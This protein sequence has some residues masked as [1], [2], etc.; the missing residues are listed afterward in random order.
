MRILELFKGTGSVGAVFRDLGHEVVSLDIE[1]KYNPTICADIM[2]WDYKS[3][4]NSGEF[5]YVVCSPVCLYWSKIRATWIG[6]K[7]KT[8]HPTDIITAEHIQKDIEEKGIPM[9]EKTFE[10]IE[11]FRPKWWWIENP[12]SSKM[13]KYIETT[14]RTYFKYTF[15]YCKYG[16]D[17][18]KPTTFITNIENIVPLRCKKDCDAIIT[19]ATRE[20]DMHQG[21]KKPIKGKTRTIHKQQLGWRKH[22]IKTINEE[23]EKYNSIGALTT[24]EQRYSIPAG[25]IRHLVIGLKN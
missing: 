1:K 16:Y 21:Y 6:R 7:C 4:Y 20:G 14:N 25:V 23:K 12:A 9:V 3:A 11:Y 8:I 17:Y 22:Q 18:K 10:I 15:D 2:E 5:D 24:R 13:W 19:I